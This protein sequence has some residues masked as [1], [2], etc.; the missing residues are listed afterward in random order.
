MGRMDRQT[1]HFPPGRGG[2]T[3]PE[4]APGVG[5]GRWAP[6]W[7][8]HPE[9]H[10]APR[11]RRPPGT[12][13][14]GGDHQRWWALAAP[15][16]RGEWPRATSCHRATTAPL[17]QRRRDC[18]DSYYYFRYKAALAAGRRDPSRRGSS[19]R[20]GK[21]P[22]RPAVPCLSVVPPARPG[23]ST[24]AAARGARGGARRWEHRPRRLP[25]VRSRRMARAK[26]PRSPSE[27]KAG[28][29]GASAGASAPEEPHGLSPLLPAR[30]GGSVGSDV[31]QR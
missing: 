31:G 27:G 30:G 9:P 10:L 26:L 20:G 18:R 8:G 28:P 12:W 22:A 7:A 13:A 23:R 1:A 24:A 15:A 11:T 14:Q 16:C 17:P 21:G 5:P 6:F 4:Q 19:A 2:P 29:G 25:P 3:Q